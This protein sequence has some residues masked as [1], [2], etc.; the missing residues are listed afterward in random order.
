MMFD[1]LIFALSFDMHCHFFLRAGLF[2]GFILFVIDLTICRF[3]AI[4]ISEISKNTAKQC[5]VSRK[6]NFPLINN[7]GACLVRINVDL[8]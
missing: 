1:I 6:T 4:N 2:C 5:G 3:D 7:F 8:Q